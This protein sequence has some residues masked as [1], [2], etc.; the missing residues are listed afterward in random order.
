MW[1]REREMGGL[2]IKREGRWLD[3]YDTF[4]LMGFGA[5]IWWLLMGLLFL[6]MGREKDRGEGLHD[7]CSHLFGCVERIV[8][9]M[10]QEGA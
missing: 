8:V 5:L 4:G 7:E 3:G 9:V 1:E 2:E 6:Q 10:L